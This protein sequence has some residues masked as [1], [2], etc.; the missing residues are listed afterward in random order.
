MLRN[1]DLVVIGLAGIACM[2]C[3]V[4]PLPD[5]VKL[6]APE[7]LCVGEWVEV[8]VSVG[9]GLVFDVLSCTVDAGADAG[10]VS[11]SRDEMFDVANPT[12]MLLAGWEPGKDYTL[13]VWSGGDPVGLATFTLT[14][15]WGLGETSDGPS[16]WFSDATGTPARRRCLG[17]R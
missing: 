11:M 12:V 4:E 6:D 1:N 2:G 9:A 10:E 14:G 8:P 15:R 5:T 13:T 16:H 7:A 17:Q 3:V